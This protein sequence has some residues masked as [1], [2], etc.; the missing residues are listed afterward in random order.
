M[1]FLNNEKVKERVRPHEAQGQPRPPAVILQPDPV[2]ASVN[3]HAADIS[4]P[5]PWKEK[6]RRSFERAFNSAATMPDSLELILIPSQRV[7]LRQL[8]K[9][10]KYYADHTCHKFRRWLATHRELDLMI[11]G[12][13]PRQIEF[14]KRTGRF[15]EGAR[16]RFTIDHIIPLNYGGTN[17]FSNLCVMPE[18]IN[19]LKAVLE[20][21]QL[22]YDPGLTEIF[23]IAPRK[24][25][26]R[27]IK[28]PYIPNAY[29]PA[30]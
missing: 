6:T 21:H 1:Y 10:R 5:A 27:Y 17:R 3:G 22:N 20:R 7:S 25:K 13:T 15:E 23:T 9:R 12:M 30:W 2:P 4:P 8:Q 26:G 19:T 18:K 16:I 11:F 24:E 14:M 29:E 28:V